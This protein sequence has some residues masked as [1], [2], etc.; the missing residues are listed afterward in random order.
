MSNGESVIE[1]SVEPGADLGSP[2]SGGNHGTHKG[3]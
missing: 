3:V 2:I 1:I